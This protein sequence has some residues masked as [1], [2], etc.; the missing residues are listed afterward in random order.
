MKTFMNFH[1]VMRP[2]LCDEQYRS[3]SSWCPV[4]VK[5][6]QLLCV[7]KVKHMV[8]QS[9]RN[10]DIISIQWKTALICPTCSLCLIQRRSEALINPT[11]WE[12]PQTLE[13]YLVLQTWTHRRHRHPELHTSLVFI[14]QF[15]LVWDFTLITLFMFYCSLRSPKN[16]QQ[17]IIK[18]VIGLEGDFIR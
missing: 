3:Y 11:V 18:R 2:V 4:C 13:D 9:V 17:K 7:R 6:L 1:F 15:L 14:R 10:S 12:R 5:L 8:C 16:P